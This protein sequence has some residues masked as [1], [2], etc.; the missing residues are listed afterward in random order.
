MSA[1]KT[2]N[3]TARPT[4]VRMSFQ[5]FDTLFHKVSNWGDGVQR[6]R[7]VRSTTSSAST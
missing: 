4:P 6:T 1:D 5:E 2:T 7:W 3:T